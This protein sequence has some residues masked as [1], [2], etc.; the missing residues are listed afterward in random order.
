[1]DEIPIVTSSDSDS[2]KRGSKEGIDV[3]SK[4]KHTT[5]TTPGLS[6]FEF[7]QEGPI[8][9][10]FY[11]SP[12]ACPDAIFQKLVTQKEEKKA[13]VEAPTP[14]KKTWFGLPLDFASPEN[15]GM[16]KA[17]DAIKKEF[18]DVKGAIGDALTRPVLDPE[19]VERSLEESPPNVVRDIEPIVS[20]KKD[21]A[22]PAQITP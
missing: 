9:S 15:G 12:G 17:M 7:V 4:S 20:V 2:Q 19:E 10:D 21:D 5:P 14:T 16:F 3:E 11:S 13:E 1:M 18:K 6:E 22:T 8:V